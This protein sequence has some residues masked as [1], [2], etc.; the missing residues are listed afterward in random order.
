MKIPE[1]EKVVTLTGF[2]YGP[3]TVRTLCNKPIVGGFF[4]LFWSGRNF[5][6]D[7]TTYRS[8]DWSTR[9][10]VFFHLSFSSTLLPLSCCGI[11]RNLQKDPSSSSSSSFFPFLFVCKT[12]LKATVSWCGKIAELS[13]TLRKRGKKKKKKRTTWLCVPH[14]TTRRPSLYK[15]RQ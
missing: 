3:D 14:Q 1:D 15:L 11:P 9:R 10:V 2:C 5:V 12:Q 4:Y 7:L 8:H 6:S 13:R